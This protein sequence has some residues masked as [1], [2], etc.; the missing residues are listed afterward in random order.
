MAKNEFEPVEKFG[1]FCSKVK[2]RATCKANVMHSMQPGE[3]KVQ[4]TRGGP[5]FCVNCAL[6]NFMNERDYLENKIAFVTEFSE[7]EKPE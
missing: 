3:T 6:Q 7:S 2:F 4:F 5:T 1:V